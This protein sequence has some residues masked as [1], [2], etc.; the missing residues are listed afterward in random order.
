MNWGSRAAF[1][2]RRPIIKF[3]IIFLT[4]LNFFYDFPFP[5]LG[6]AGTVLEN[7]PR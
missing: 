6:N 7:N 1:W 5:S 2:I 4:V 3:V